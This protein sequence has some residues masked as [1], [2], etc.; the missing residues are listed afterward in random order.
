MLKT[1]GETGLPAWA[2]LAFHSIK[3]WSTHNETRAKLEWTTS[4]TNS[5][6]F[7][8]RNPLVLFRSQKIKFYRLPYFVETC[9]RNIRFIEAL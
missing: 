5:A 4:S 6:V 3:R 1:Y 9:G 8:Q 2:I 7:C